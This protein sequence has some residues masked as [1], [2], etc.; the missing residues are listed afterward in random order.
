MS[1]VGQTEPLSEPNKDNKTDKTKD[2]KNTMEPLVQF[3]ERAQCHQRISF[4]P[5]SSRNFLAWSDAGVCAHK[6]HSECDTAGLSFHAHRS[7]H[8]MLCCAVFDST[9]RGLDDTTF[10]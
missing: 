3:D 2:M 1:K 5:K 10:V 9:S 6:I 7:K 8:V 4:G